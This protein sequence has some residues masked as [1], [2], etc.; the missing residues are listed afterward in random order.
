MAKKV[1]VVIGVPTTGMV[2]ADFAMSLATI[3]HYTAGSKDVEVASIVNQKTSIIQKGRHDIVKEAQKLE[4]DKLLFLDSDMVFPPN[5][6]TGLAKHKKNI[7]G[8]NYA[9]RVHPIKPT[10]R[11]ENKD[12]I[13]L[14][15]QGLIEV[16]YLGTG[17]LMVD[18][19][20][21]DK[22]G[23]PYF[24]VEYKDKAFHGED[25]NFC[26]DAREAGFKVFCDT[27]LSKEVRHL[28]QQ[29]FMV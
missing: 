27:N 19:K 22:I 24:R 16:G 14:K 28:G 23:D 21:F 2:H 1:K 18:M 15:P 17:S 4:A 8:C 25:Y 20:V 13:S 6:L 3:V 26:K 5:L 29:E 12:F 7:V 10:A 9:T 11:F